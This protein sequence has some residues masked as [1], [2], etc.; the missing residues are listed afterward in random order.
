M[1]L[2]SLS[3][4]TDFQEPIPSI[5]QKLQ[6]IVQ[7]KF[8]C[9]DQKNHEL[10]SINPLFWIAEKIKGFFGFNDWS[11]KRLIE[12]KIIELLS[13]NKDQFQ[14]SDINLIAS[15][16]AKAGLTSKYPEKHPELGAVIQKISG[17]LLQTHA[18]S[19]YEYEDVI[20]E[21]YQKYSPELNRFGTILPKI[22][23]VYA[24]VT[25]Q[26][27][28]EPSITTHT[29]VKEEDFKE[30]NLRAENPDELSLSSTASFLPSSPTI[31][32]SNTPEMVPEATPAVKEIA[33][34]PISEQSI[35][36]GIPNPKNPFTLRCINAC[37]RNA[38]NQALRA[39]NPFLEKL[40]TPII[41]GQ[42]WEKR[43]NIRAA[44]CYL[45]ECLNKPESSAV[46][47]EA[48]L[49]LR[50]A[51]FESRLSG[52][53]QGEE[54]LE[55]QQDAAAYL[56][57]ILGTVLGSYLNVQLDY[58]VEVEGAKIPLHSTPESHALVQIAIQPD[59]SQDFQSQLNAY[60]ADTLNNTSFQTDGQVFDSFYEKR[61]LI[62]D[63]S[64]FLAIQLKRGQYNEAAILE[65][66]EQE[67]DFW[68][69]VSNE[70]LSEEQRDALRIYL[71]EQA[72]NSP[73][74]NEQ[75]LRFPADNRIKIDQVDA[76]GQAV[77]LQYEIKSFIM[78]E[79]A[80]FSP[81]GHYTSYIVKNGQW[82]YCNDELVIPVSQEKVDQDKQKAYILFF[83]QI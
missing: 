50:N 28:K 51:V 29:S 64:G 48:E 47:G 12:L 22:T 27:I 78:R 72:K 54:L 19:A 71:L 38:S 57:T 40:Q 3:K 49:A 13:V 25:S 44:L 80:D 45:Y 63:P 59:I 42:N 37:Y 46:I 26:L 16:A 1:S 14:A 60:F 69:E 17:E 34:S 33:N 21:F 9:V 30:S 82:Y 23:E 20:Q 43:E 66:I 39:L 52:D 55:E 75:A 68:T 10:K 41:N 62:D 67:I 65:R 24:L 73:Q 6:A 77:A 79:A 4:N 11:N 5:Q 56:E 35:I 83:E 61:S 58:Y 81:A 53:L 76:M 32:L 7:A 15:V 70:V 18:H 36:K 2:P 74:I 8:L 31:E